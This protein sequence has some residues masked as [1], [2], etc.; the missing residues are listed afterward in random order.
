MKSYV[1]LGY[2]NL[3]RRRSR[4][5]LTVLGI[6]LA[7]GFTVGLLSISEGFMRSLDNILTSA[8]PELFVRPK[9]G[10]K[11]PFGIQGTALLDENLGRIVRGI[12]G[13]KYVEPVYMAFS[14][15]GGMTGFGAMMTM[16]SGLPCKDFFKVRPDAQ[17]ASG[18]FFKN[19]NE[20]KV[21]V[22]GSVV[23]ENTKKKIGDTLELINGV[24]LKVIGVMKKSNEPY[25]YF[26]YAPIATLQNIYGDKNEVSYFLI[27]SDGKKSIE[28]VS[29]LLAKAFPHLDVQTVKELITEAKKMLSMA[30]AVHVGVSCFALVIGVLFVAC[31]MIMSVSERI[32]EFATL[33]VIGASKGFVAKMILSESVILSVAGGA[34]G[35][36]FGFMLSKAIDLIIFHFVGDTFFSTYVSPRIF[37][38]GFSI[39][40]LIGAFA[41]LLPSFMILRRNLSDSLRYE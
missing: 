41:G 15:D 8:G 5:F 17:L 16:V 20:G 11:M 19:D 22:L 40:L 38:T 18:R 12:P 10:S 2:R 32:R 7:I 14:V 28:S 4:S 31:T 3:S 26:A 35:C 21:V 39:A 34:A 25:D 27:K 1:K 33:R 9:G 37:I 23:A 24:K 6:I 36:L 30:R 13:V 29:K